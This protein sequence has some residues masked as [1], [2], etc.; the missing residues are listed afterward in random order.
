MLDFQL[1]RVK[2]FPENQERLFRDE[3]TPPDILKESILTV[4][5]T[6]LRKGR[7]WHIGNVSEIGENA[8]YFR[9]GRLATSTLEVYSDGNFV[10]REF[11]TAPYTHCILDI[12]IELAAIAKKTSLASRV[13]TIANCLIRLLNLSETAEFYGATFEIDY[14]TDPEDFIKHLETAYEITRFWVD[15]SRPNVMDVD[16]LLVGPFEKYIEAAD[17]DKGRAIVEGKGLKLETA[18][19]VARSAATTG[20]DA[21]A[22]IKP[23]EKA[24]KIRKRLK[25]NPLIARWD[26]LYDEEEMRNFRDYL[27]ELY[28]RIREGNNFYEDL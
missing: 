13:E 5:K 6:E 25:T 18:E 19:A 11:E 16:K 22:T 28:R 20:D 21:G 8:I 15:I 9:I 10:D 27:R 17:G 1:F 14:L 24:R 12:D 4:H 26:D 7:V 23:D 3:K 2:V